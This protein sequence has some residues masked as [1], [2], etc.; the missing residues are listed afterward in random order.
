MLVLTVG[1]GVQGFTL[2]TLIGEWVLTHRWAQGWVQQQL[3]GWV[4]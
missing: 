2:D 1:A 3:T 4:L